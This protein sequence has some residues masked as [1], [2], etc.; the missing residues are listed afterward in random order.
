MALGRLCA[1]L[2]IDLAAAAKATAPWIDEEE[3][4]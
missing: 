2:G 3:R 1:N 4:H